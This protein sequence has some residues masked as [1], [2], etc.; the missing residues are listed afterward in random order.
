M[1]PLSKNFDINLRRD[2]KK[3]NPYERRNYES[4]DKKSLS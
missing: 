2:L 4:E 1:V 3:I